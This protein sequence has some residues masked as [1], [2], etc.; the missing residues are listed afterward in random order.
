MREYEWKRGRLDMTPGEK[1]LFICG[2]PALVVA[3]VVGIV[4]A[5]LTLGGMLFRYDW[6]LALAIAAIG[7]VLAIIIAIVRLVAA[8]P[9]WAGHQ[10]RGG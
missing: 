10:L 3:G 5:A 6:R 8:L 9:A 7:F 1:A 2:V 4:W